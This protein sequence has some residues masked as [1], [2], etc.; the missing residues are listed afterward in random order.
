MFEKEERTSVGDL[1]AQIK[2][3]MV[4]ALTSEDGHRIQMK[5]GMN[6][7]GLHNFVSGIGRSEESGDRTA[8]RRRDHG[9]FYGEH[10]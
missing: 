2:R 4:K 7:L 6:Y 5:G 3:S 1:A 9:D 10:S 8:H